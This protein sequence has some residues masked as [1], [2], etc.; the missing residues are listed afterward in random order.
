MNYQE[1]TKKLFEY[2]DHNGELVLATTD[3]ERTTARIISTFRLNHKLYFQTDTNST[4]YKQLLKQPKIALADDHYSIEGIASVIGKT[5]DPAISSWMD[6]Y[7]AKWP[8]AHKR[9]SKMDISRLIEINIQQVK[10][11]EMIDGAPYETYIDFVNG[12]FEVK[13]YNL[14]L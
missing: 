4:K 13:A 10:A 1:A 9:Y 2:L 5:T 6:H 14:N 3:G 7:E 8:E 11:W 12:N